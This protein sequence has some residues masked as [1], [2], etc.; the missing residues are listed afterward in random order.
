MNDKDPHEDHRRSPRCEAQPI[1][2]AQQTAALYALDALLPSEA[3]AFE[4][5]LESGCAYCAAET[6]AFREMLVEVGKAIA[7]RSASPP[8]DLRGRLLERIA[9]E[10]A[11]DGTDVVVQAWKSWKEQPG[12]TS[13]GLSTVRSSEGH[14]ERLAVPG[15]FAK[16]LAVD[17]ERR[18][19]TMLIRMEPG[20]SYPSHRHAG[21]EQCFVLEGTL[22][23]GG[24]TLHAGDY[25]QASA[26]STH[27]VQSTEEGCLLLIV[28]SQDD[29][30]L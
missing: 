22:Q 11:A 24:E 8:A 26:D 5:H 20:T 28:S 25:Q 6:A 4:K 18:C 14:W 7:S 13:S 10:P 3:S 27:G 12:L 9:L 2:S 23:V 19:T 30:L 16:K 21:I 29:E 1:E 17:H 15:V